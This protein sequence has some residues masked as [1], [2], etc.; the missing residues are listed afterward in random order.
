MQTYAHSDDEYDEGNK[1]YV[2]KTLDYRSNNGSKFIR[3]LEAWMDRSM[4]TSGSA[5]Q[6]RVRKLPRVP[7]QSKLKSPP[8]QLPLDFYDPKWYNALT[9]SQKEKFVKNSQV[10]LLPNAAQSLIPAP[11]THPD[12][13]ISGLKFNKKYYDKLK[14]PYHIN[15]AGDDSDEDSSGPLTRGDQ[16]NHDEEMNDSIDL[17]GTSEGSDDEDKAANDLFYEDGDFGELYDEEEEEEDGDWGSSEKEDED[18]EGASSNS[19]DDKMD[20]GERI[21]EEEL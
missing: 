8:V 18:T 12:E 10:A 17:E 19:E 13:K 21:E 5:A 6:K 2:I 3:R 16:T 20:D 14:L 7:Q 1:V 15:T 9:A 4:K 11:N